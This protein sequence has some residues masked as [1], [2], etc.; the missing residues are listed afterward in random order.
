MKV[1]FTCQVC[2]C[3]VHSGTVIREEVGLSLDRAG[4]EVLGHAG[5]VVLSKDS[6][7][8]VGDGSTQ[9]AVNKRIAQIKRIVEVQLCFIDISDVDQQVALLTILPYWIVMQATEQDYEKEKLNERIAK[10]SGGVAVIQ[11]T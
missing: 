8:I 2:F 7:T 10:L 9:E 1:V 4:S 6:T 3:N 5:K 11:V